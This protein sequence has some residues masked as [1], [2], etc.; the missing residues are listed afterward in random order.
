MG[1]EKIMPER[2]S[3]PMKYDILP[4]S[5]SM[6]EKGSGFLC[7]KMDLVCVLEK[8]DTLLLIVTEQTRSLTFGGG[9]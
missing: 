5:L 4:M 9:L 3:S 7:P 8:S 2:L 6:T 1:R